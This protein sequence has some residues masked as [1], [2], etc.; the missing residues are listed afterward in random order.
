MLDSLVRKLSKLNKQQQTQNQQSELSCSSSSFSSTSSQS[1][2]NKQPQHHQQQT[3]CVMLE[4][5][6]LNQSPNHIL[7]LNRIN[8]T[9][10]CNCNSDL[11]KCS[12]IKTKLFDIEHI[13]EEI[14]EDNHNNKIL[15]K[16]EFINETVLDKN[17]HLAADMAN[18]NKK[19]K[20]VRFKQN[21]NLPIANEMSQFKTVYMTQKCMP[22][23]QLSNECDNLRFIQNNMCL[24]CT[25]CIK[26]V[27][28]NSI[29]KKPLETDLVYDPNQLIA[30]PVQLHVHPSYL[31]ISNENLSKSST[32]SSSS[33]SSSSASSSFYTT[34]SINSTT[35]SLTSNHSQ[36]FNQIVEDFLNKVTLSTSNPS[37]TVNTLYNSRKKEKLINK[38]KTINSEMNSAIKNSKS[39]INLNSSITDNDRLSF[40]VTNLTI[41]DLKLRQKQLDSLK[42]SNKLHEHVNNNKFVPIQI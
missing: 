7:P 13:Y 28:L 34:N 31:E 38:S 8:Q 2:I 22:S 41:D 40:R 5:F 12:T 21:A 9:C 36:V 23:I 17:L 16:E 42:K 32:A 6:D 35:S 18:T 33:S 4:L 37:S 27:Y 24:N 25:N 20:C 3:N 14:E 29:L 11:N 39:E 30:Q 26:Q 15:L 10:S 19:K 1:S